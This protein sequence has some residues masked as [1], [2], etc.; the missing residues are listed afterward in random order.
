MYIRKTHTNN[1]STGERY[2]TYR[3]V[4]SQRV[5]G[6][7]RQMTLLNLGR[8]FAVDQ[9]LWAS[10]C[11]RIE[12]LLSH[13]VELLPIELPTTVEKAA[14]RI[15]AQLIEQRAVVIKPP[16]ADGGHS[17]PAKSSIAPVES[18]ATE[19][20]PADL[21]TVD[22]DS[23]ELTRPR[24]VGV[25]QL[26]LWA[27][28]QLNFLD[29]LAQLGINGAQIAAI[30]GSIIGRMAGLGS[31][32]ATHTWLRKQSALG[33]LLEV[34]YESMPLMTM[35]RAADALWKHSTEIEQTLFTRIT[36]LFGFSTTITL[37]DLTNT[38][39]EGEVPHNTKARR[40]HSKEKR[41]D[42]PLVTLGLVL[43]G[44]G[45]VRRSQTFA[46]NVSEASTLET[47]LKD[48]GAPPDALVVMDAGI[49]TEA[50]I[51][52]LRT[53]GYGYLVVSRERSRQF[54]ADAAVSLETAAQ[55]TVRCQKV[56]AED[57]QEVRLYC[58]SSGREQ[59]EQAMAE[60]FA[61]R[62]EAG[63]DALNAGLQ[64]PRTEKRPAKVWER[65]GRL[66]EKQHGIGQ[67]YQIDVQT[68]DSGEKALSITWQKHRVPG[69]FID[70]PGV[71]CLRSSQTQ[72]TE[73][74][75]WRTYMMLTDLEAVFR[76][77]KSDLGFRPVFH[78][79]EE[80]ADSHLFITVLAYQ[81]VQLIR[82][83]LKESD[84]DFT[85]SWGTLREIM[86]SQCRVTASFRRAD[87]KALHI[88]KA[89]RAEPEQ[90]AIYQALKVNPAP[91]GI[92]KTIV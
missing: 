91:G 14:Q 84:A 60:R 81:L 87:G 72:W 37:Y 49:A 15:A 55:E 36:D 57:G 26:G 50:N 92:S 67:H 83:R 23:L 39:F 59:K 24:T 68:D 70:L 64:R 47:M 20:A 43:D 30:V 73:A 21:Q 78:H 11:A 19:T 66:K 74:E 80:R 53:T 62:F 85:S 22:V 34:D 61:S 90:M 41:T 31:E 29:L 44:S 13:Q 17:T 18:V 51:Q 75:L 89:T 86:R 69:S 65:I 1:S 3:L 52:W 40:G 33:E 76:C 58:H 32:L 25:E 12:Q 9:D 79:K 27:M 4:T 71:Y 38:Y 46:G 2:Y 10:L 35:Y 16:L 5:D 6:K 7:P 48:L 42:C 82:R 28:Q 8:H 54:N 77:F 88:R 56:I 63:L 45:F